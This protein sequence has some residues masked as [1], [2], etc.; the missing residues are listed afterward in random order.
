MSNQRIADSHWDRSGIVACSYCGDCFDQ[1]FSPLDDDQLCK[2][3]QQLII[4]NSE[5]EMNSDLDARDRA[6][7][8]RDILGTFWR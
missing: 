7:D 2:A 3:C 8:V 6:R 5:D 1:D 4:D